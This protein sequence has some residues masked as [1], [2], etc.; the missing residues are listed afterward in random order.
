MNRLDPNNL[1]EITLLREITVKS[2]P[3]RRPADDDAHD[4]GE[5]SKPFHLFIVDAFAFCL[6][7]P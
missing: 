7:Y 4:D 6:K 1:F 5:I 3:K 2:V